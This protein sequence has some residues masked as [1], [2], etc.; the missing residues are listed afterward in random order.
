MVVCMRRTVTASNP[1]FRLSPPH[2]FSSVL[3]VLQSCLPQ[4]MNTQTAVTRKRRGTFYENRF[5]K[6]AGYVI[7]DVLQVITNPDSCFCCVRNTKMLYRVCPSVLN[8]T[9][10]EI[11]FV[12]YYI[13]SFSFL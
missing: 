8:F 6:V 1:I 2:S 11:V 9:T 3:A 10:A 4:L 7:G 5:S 12:I 13:E